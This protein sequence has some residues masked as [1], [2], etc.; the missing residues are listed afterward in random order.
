[1][2]GDRCRGNARLLKAAEM[3]LKTPGSGGGGGCSCGGG[4]G[5]GSVP[6]DLV[7]MEAPVGTGPG[8][9]SLPAVGGGEKGSASPPPDR[10][11]LSSTEPPPGQPGGQAPGASWAWGRLVPMP[12]RGGCPVF[13]EAPCTGVSSGGPSSGGP[14]R[15][16]GP[17]PA[18]WTARPLPGAGPQGR[19][20]GV[21]ARPGAGLS[22]SEGPLR[23]RCALRGLPGSSG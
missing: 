23:G 21:L 16:G 17:A 18:R 20:L 14:G 12:R 5:A 10:G 11:G 2:G 7:E 13:W 3:R 19:A 9:P 4:G 8:L 15:L 1:M 22:D 6:V